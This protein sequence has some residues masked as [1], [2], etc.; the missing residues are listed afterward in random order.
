MKYNEGDKVRVK[1]KEWY[2]NNK[3]KYGNVERKC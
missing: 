3:D 2:N 1:S